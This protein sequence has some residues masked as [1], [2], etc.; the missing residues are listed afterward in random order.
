MADIGDIY[1]NLHDAVSA[2]VPGGVT[3]VFEHD[4]DPL[5][6]VPFVTILILSYLTTGRGIRDEVDDEGE[7]TITLHSKAAASIRAFGSTPQESMSILEFVHDGFWLLNTRDLLGREIAY[8]RTIRGPENATTLVDEE[9]E[10]SAVLEVEFITVRDIVDEVGLIETI[11]GTG[12][13]EG[14]SIDISISEEDL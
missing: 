11:E 1:L 7:Q 5:P 4:N 10:P 14:K 9:W 3:V 6:E 12:I 8:N 2:N 13:V